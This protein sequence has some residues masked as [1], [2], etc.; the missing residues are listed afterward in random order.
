[1]TPE[2]GPCEMKRLI[3]VGN[4]S[5]FVDNRVL[6]Q[7]FEVYG[8][9][10]SAV[11][12]RHFETGRSTGVGYV[13]MESNKGGAAAIAALNHHHHCGRVLSVSWIDSSKIRAAG[14]DQMFGPTSMARWSHLNAQRSGWENKEDEITVI[15]PSPENSSARASLLPHL[16]P[17][18]ETTETIFRH[19][20][21]APYHQK[22]QHP[23]DSTH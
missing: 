6:Q 22:Q 11:I 9:V 1:M 10:R 20:N 12:N 4:L 7:L 13:E 2:N 17:A 21:T 18:A 23:T 5:E 8:G 19:E 14:C 16:H 15:R 3:Q